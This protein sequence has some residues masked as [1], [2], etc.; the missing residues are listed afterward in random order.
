MEFRADLHPRSCLSFSY[1]IWKQNFPNVHEHTHLRLFHQGRRDERMLTVQSFD[2]CWA[3]LPWLL[4]L[5]RG[6]LSLLST[7][8]TAVGLMSV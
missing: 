2:R 3:H 5:F 4:T 7:A 6:L 8:V 1:V